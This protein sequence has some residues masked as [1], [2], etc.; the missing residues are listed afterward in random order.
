MGK[1][2]KRLSSV[3]GILFIAMTFLGYVP[4]KAAEAI[5]EVAFLGVEHS[6]LVEGDSETFYLSAMG[7]E[8]VQ[9]RI[10]QNK[11]GSDKWEELTPNYTNAGNANDITK[12]AGSA[13]YEVGKYKLSIWVKKAD[14]EGK[15]KNKNGGYD[16]YYIAYLNCVNKDNNNRVYTNGDMNIEK[17]NYVVGETI[18]VNGIKDI[19]GM[20]DPYTYKL[21]VYDVNDNA[22][23]LDNVDYRKEISFLADKPGTYVLDVWAMSSNSTLW[24]KEAKLNG[25]I[26]EAWKLKVITVTEKKVQ[27][28]ITEINIKENGVI[29]GSKDVKNPMEINKKINITANDV[30]LNNANVKGTVTIPGNN[31]TLNNVKVEGTLILNP[32]EKGT[33]K[34]DNVTA[35]NIEVLSGAANSI[36]FNNVTVKTLKVN[37]TNTK[38]SVRIEIKGKTSIEKTEV[39]SSV[40]LDAAEG[41]F[42]NVEVLENQNKTES[43]IELRGSFDKNI[44]VKT[45]ATLKTAKDTKILKVIIEPE[46]NEKITLDGKFGQVEVNKKAVVATTENTK[47]EK[48][49]TNSP[50]VLELGKGSTVS[51]L[52]QNGQ[53]VTQTGLGTVEKKVNPAKPTP[54]STGGGSGGGSDS[55]PTYKVAGVS[56]NKTSS[57]LAINDILELTATINPSNAT[58]KN[59]TWTSSDSLVAKV[60]SNAGAKVGIKAIGVGTATITVTTED[61]RK[62]AACI[63]KVAKVPAPTYAVTGVS[64]DKTTASTTS[65]QSI[66]LTATI[67][68]ENATNKNVT[69][70]SSNPLVAAVTSGAG[71]KANVKATGVGT[72][73]ITVTTEDGR[74]TATCTIK[75]AA[76][77]VPVTGVSLNKTTADLKVAEELKLTAII[78]PESATNKNVTWSS[79]NPLVAKVTGSTEAMAD[80]KAIG[81][82]TATITVTTEDGGKI[83]TCIITVAKVPAPTYA[84]T[85]VSLDKTTASITSGQSIELTATINPESATNK[86]VTW[87]SSNPLVAAVTG[88]SGVKAD[89]SAIGVGTAII[90]VTT[91]DGGKIATCAI[92]VE[93][94]TS[95]AIELNAVVKIEQKKVTVSVDNIKVA[96]QQITIAI[97]KENKDIAFIDQL[98]A[99]VAGKAAFNT[100]LEVGKYHGLVKASNASLSTKLDFE[101][102]QTGISIKVEGV[103]LNKTTASATTGQSIEL[104]ATINPDNATNKN[105]TWTSSNEAV[106]KVTS[107]I[108]AMADIK[109]IGAGTAIITVTTEDGGKIATC[110]ITVE[111]TTS[112]AIELNA[113]VKIEQKKVTVSVDNIKVANQQITIAIYKENKDIAFIDQLTAD[114]AGKAAFNT[115]LE[116]G[117]YHGLVK[118]SNASLS[119]KLDFEIVQTGISIKVE[120]VSLNKTTASVTT[121]Q[122]IELVATINPDNAI[123]KNVTWS[124][125]N[126]A[127]AK[128]IASTEARA[129]VSAIG[130]G[131]AVI[132]VT[133]ADGEKTA[134]CVITVTATTT[135]AIDFNVSGMV[136]AVSDDKKTASLPKAGTSVRVDT[137][138]F[139]KPIVKLDDLLKLVATIQ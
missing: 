108:G 60:T 32:G 7:A 92:T 37:S 104:I 78:N 129:N 42:G 94:T 43:L 25:R 114:V 120:G 20:K 63:I 76:V 80:I 124:S 17:D 31:A 88:G 137:V 98:T 118:A 67:N 85:G 33:V 136:E 138:N 72:A 62:T 38:E 74:K 29:Y 131:T 47:I 126:E 8:K 13:K 56:L 81:V 89:I 121:G 35:D 101:I 5:T 39:K 9:Y 117:K 103:T 95:P 28:E 132:T 79:S 99:D 30:V 26:Y 36:H 122:S 130:A 12:V 49:T 23:K 66:E 64:L 6:P 19:S 84:V 68:P 16:S 113:V 27:P 77:P 139:Y 115:I 1:F 112:P 65:G 41:S 46:N 55:K 54:P 91:E 134:I 75:V 135:A 71:A 133:T 53:T 105:V 97:Y 86:N 82:G 128:V 70:T 14:T 4:A 106:A 24:G 107:S 90:T 45:K 2:K 100:I 93:T 87:T 21:H 110:A 116:V 51:T 48:I 10:F 3:L 111:T 15:F 40:I 18:K 109:A 22:W 73:T 57:E 127:V 52:D 50:V 119:T 125:S 34:L 83:A 11:I 59:V 96:N 61:G 58:N 44:I 102:V 69:W 123:N